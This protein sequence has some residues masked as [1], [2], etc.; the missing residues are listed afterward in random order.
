MKRW[1]K[2]AEEIIILCMCTKNH[3]IS[4]T[5][6]EIQSETGRIFCYFGL[7]LLF[8]PSN[9]PKN[10]N[11][12]TI[13]KRPGDTIFYTMKKRPGDIIL[14]HMCIINEDN[15]MYGFWNIRHNRIFCHFG[16]FFALS[17]PWQ[18]QKSRFWKIERTT[19]RYYHLTHV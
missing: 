6:S 9:D 19:W 18:P 8:Y 5:V 11:F 7:F 16:P 12:E 17:S 14:L 13:K 10:Q 15:M 4:C 1:K 2:I 3:I